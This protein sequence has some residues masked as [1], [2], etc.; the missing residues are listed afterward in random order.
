MALLFVAQLSSIGFAQSGGVISTVA[1]NGTWG[2]SRDGGPA[3]SA[4]LYY[5]YGVAV[6]TAGNL[7]IADYFN[8][9][10][11]KVTP[12]GVISTVAGNGTWGFSG[13]GGPANSAQLSGPY[14]VAVDTPANMFIADSNNNRIRKVT[15]GGVIS[16]V[17]G[18][19][20]SG[21]SGDGGPANS[22]QLSSPYGIAVDAAGNLFIA[23]YG[24]QRIRKVTPGGIISTVAGNGTS[25]FSGDG[26]P[27]NSA[28]LY[29]PSGVAVDTAGNLFIADQGNNC[30]RKVT[31]GGVISTVAGNGAWGFSG[32]GGP[33]N[34]AQLYGPAGVAVDTAG[35]L[36][37]AD[38][39]NQR[40]RKVTLGGVISTVAGNGTEGFSG[41]GGTATSAQLHNPSG[42]TVD[43]AGN[44]FIGDTGNQRVRKVAGGS[45]VS[46]DLTSGGSATSYT[47]GLNG[48]TQTGYATAA[49]N[50][51]AAPYGTAVF[52]FKQNGVTVSEAGVPA[53][54]PTTEARIFIDYRSSVAAIP[55][56]SSAGTVNIDTGIAVVNYGSAS[57][58]L[59]YTLRNVAGTT[60]STGHGILAAGAHF[61]TFIDLLNA[62]APDFVLP[63]NFQTATQFAS[64]EIS[65][66]Q[67]ISVLAL[68]MT[69]NQRNEALFTTTPTADLTKPTTNAVIFFPQFADGGGYTTSL[70]LLNT[71]NE[72]ETG[73]LQLLN[74]SGNP[75]DVN[76][77]GSTA[78]AV[79]RYSIPNGGAF[80][81]QTDGS[82]ATLTTGWAQLT[83][84]AG[85]STPI[86]AGVFG[87]NPG[88]I[89]VTESGIPATVSTTHA[90]IYVDLSGGHN[91][92]LAIA[93]PT[94][95]NASITI[96]AFQSDGATGIGTSQGPLQ[97]PAKG[98]SAHFANEFIAGLPAGF[99]GVLD[100]I[101]ST[102][103]AALTMRSLTNERKDF[104]LATFP[105]ADMMLG[106]PS[107]IV[108]PQIADGGGYV[109]QFILIG[110]GGA[111]SM[112]LNYYGEDGKPLPVGKRLEMIGKGFWVLPTLSAILL[113]VLGAWLAHRLTTRR[114]RKKSLRDS[115]TQFRSAFSAALA[116]LN[117]GKDIHF[118]MS[119]AAVRHDAA[120]DEFRRHL[121]QGKLKGF[122]AACDE[123]RSQRQADPAWLQICRSQ[124][125]EKTIEEALENN[126]RHRVALVAAING[127]LAFAKP[128]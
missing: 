31:P 58:N 61:A 63:L 2:Y 26:G 114:D 24:N 113:L 117:A 93:N 49:I 72:T 28:Q 46:M 12:G 23:D 53:S 18:N 118:I 86:G 25:G 39:G 44:L 16:T 111:S 103:F 45:S 92:G 79:F 34:S 97:L 15:P 102:P 27:A 89:L 11:R 67:L 17:A 60:L 128:P 21:F 74:G 91:T 127:L 112:T 119:S 29:N 94:N 110:A 109:T 82:P 120:I 47:A 20:T 77:V 65:S 101:S 14:G 81:F 105:I 13:D 83:P 30:V 100:I 52:S 106:A 54:P 43:T 48:T 9:R 75:L 108:F 70:V 35:N 80:R 55:G 8:K 73:T 125:P 6:D 71:S 66:D 38:S 121:P 64:L 90:R 122:D 78:G 42:V 104:L 4:Q 33:A 88:N 10:V 76:Q 87:Y 5:P 56:R 99:T 62:V 32:D 50:A 59:T 57:A 107:P 69:T 40:I 96:T 115:C 3:T 85:T 123:Y 22:A 124:A 37:I 41:D 36:F 126:K 116:E 19:G 95:T 51:G 1:G 7:F 68:R 98:H 84:D